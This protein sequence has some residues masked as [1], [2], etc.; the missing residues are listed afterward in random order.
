M[1]HLSRLYF[2]TASAGEVSERIAV[3]AA[4]IVGGGKE[5]KLSIIRKPPSRSVRSRSHAGTPARLRRLCRGSYYA[6]AADATLA[7]PFAACS[8]LRPTARQIAPSS[9]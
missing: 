3:V 9:T 4:S 6:R 1:E 7:L 2:R 8:S 5:G